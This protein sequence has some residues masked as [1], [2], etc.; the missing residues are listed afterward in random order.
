MHCGYMLYWEAKPSHL[1]ILYTNNMKTN[2]S[3]HCIMGLGVD[4][5]HNRVRHDGKEFYTLPV[6]KHTRRITLNQTVVSLP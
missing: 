2:T 5:Y 4:L 6:K 3:A 1:D